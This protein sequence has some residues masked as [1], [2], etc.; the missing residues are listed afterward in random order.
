MDGAGSSSQSANQVALPVGSTSVLVHLTCQRESACLRYLHT[1]FRLDNGGNPLTNLRWSELQTF[2]VSQAS[3][4]LA[5]LT[6]L[7]SGPG[8]CASGLRLSY[9]PHHVSNCVLLMQ[10]LHVPSAL[11]EDCMHIFFLHLVAGCMLQLN[12][13]C[14]LNVFTCAHPHL[15]RHYSVRC[16]HR[17]LLLQ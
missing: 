1:T 8:L 16:P 4:C 9:N 12:L 6:Q 7:Q 2:A 13:H 5:A 3:L 15:T 10:L 14:L 11:L 17:V